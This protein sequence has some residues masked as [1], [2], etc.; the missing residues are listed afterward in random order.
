MVRPTAIVYVDGFNLYRRSLQGRRGVKWLNP[1]ALAEY[2][3]PDYQVLR[4]HYFSARV[5]PGIDPDESAPQRQQ[6]YLRALATLEPRL[7]V[8]LGTFRAD[9][10][11]MI[12]L[13]K[14]ADESNQWQRVRVLKVEEKGSDVN[15]AARMV[16]DSLTDRCDVVVLLSNDSDHVGQISMLTGEF[17][18]KVGVLFP[19]QEHGK[20]NRELRK[21]N[22]EFCKTVTLES[23]LASQLPSK[24]SDKHGEIQ[25]PA[26]WLNTEGLD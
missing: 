19:Y 2:L 1:I 13:P 22:L 16:A 7:F 24:L 8:T 23:L 4:V 21:L 17:A 3:L 5:K 12:S 25:A 20:G 10:R 6:A 15:L 14:L 11:D 26:S 18:K 9:A